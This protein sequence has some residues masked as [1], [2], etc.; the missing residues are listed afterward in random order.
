MPLEHSGNSKHH[1]KTIQ[2]FISL[3]SEA[4]I[5]KFPASYGFTIAYHSVL[6]WD[7]NSVSLHTCYFSKVNCNGC[8]VTCQAGSDGRQR[9]NPTL[10]L[11]LALDGGGWST[12]LPS[13]CHP[14]KDPVPSEPVW[15]DPE[16]NPTRRVSNPGPSIPLQVATPA[17]LSRP[18]P[19]S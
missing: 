4:L 16:M 7:T 9:Y 10:S 8:S 17:V 12:P 11:T 5:K 3:T 6:S 19:I 14:G 13:R 15:T 18:P 1:S 2:C